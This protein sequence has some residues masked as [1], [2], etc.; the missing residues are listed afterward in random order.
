MQFD[1]KKH[2]DNDI[3]NILLDPKYAEDEEDLPNILEDLPKSGNIGSFI[4]NL[5]GKYQAQLPI[6]PDMP[7][8]KALPSLESLRG[9]WNP[10]L[11][12]AVDYAHMPI[13]DPEL[14]KI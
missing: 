9:G 4:S 1:P 11:M 8:L 13:F 7:E 10:D 3:M 6:V 14:L 5:H 12:P 2:F